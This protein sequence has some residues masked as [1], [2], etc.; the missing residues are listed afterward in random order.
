MRFLSPITHY[1]LSPLTPGFHTRY[2]PPSGFLN[3]LTVYSSTRFQAFFHALYIYGVYPKSFPLTSSIDDSSPPITFTVDVLYATPCMPAVSL[4]YP[5]T[6]QNKSDGTCDSANALIKGLNPPLSP[7]TSHLVLPKM[8]GRY[9]PGLLIPLPSCRN[10]KNS[11][12]AFDNGRAWQNPFPKDA[13]ASNGLPYKQ[14][15]SVSSNPKRK[16]N[17]IG[18]S[19]SLSYPG[20]VF[21]SSPLRQAEQVVTSNA[22]PR[23]TFHP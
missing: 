1:E 20:F 2:V 8:G 22:G 12:W 6:H 15:A 14:N 3:L 21:S 19:Q 16:E 4:P 23:F 10:P 13:L 18:T 7:F 17:E 11:T 9:S 5:T